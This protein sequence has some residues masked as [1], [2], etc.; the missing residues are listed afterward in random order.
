MALPQEAQHSASVAHLVAQSARVLGGRTLVL[1]TTLRA[2]RTIAEV[3]RQTL[4]PHDALEVLVQ[5]EM[6]KRALL[7]RF[8]GGSALS[9][10]RG[11]I[12]VASVSFWEGIDLPGSAL[13]LVVIDKI[14]FA[15]PDDPLVQARAQS[16][17]LA[18]KNAFMHY[19]LPQAALALKQGAGRLIRSETDQGVLV[20]CDVRLLHKGYGR[21]LIAA[22]PPMRRLHTPEEF[23]Q[24]LAAITTAST[25][26]RC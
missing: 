21:K 11:C 4:P 13:Q 26:G 9:G 6:P 18:G 16:V 17:V 7:Q 22:M 14:P 10:G 15:P 2:M 5:G 23:R 25:T 20:V 12:L 3:L 8:G 19:H 1:T 24:A